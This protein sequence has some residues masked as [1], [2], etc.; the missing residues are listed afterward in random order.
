MKKIYITPETS[1]FDIHLHQMLANSPIG[2]DVYDDYAD[3]GASGL[4]KRDHGDIWG[5][6]SF[7]GQDW[8][9]TWE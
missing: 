1:E 8:G 9:D 7:S 4:T 3:D 5:K 2:S 6:S